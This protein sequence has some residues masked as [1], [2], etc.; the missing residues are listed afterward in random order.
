MITEGIHVFWK[1]KGISSNGFLKQIRKIT[2]IRKVGHAGTLDPLAEGILVVGVGKGTKLLTKI[3]GAEKE[4]LCVARLG[5]ISETDDEEGIKTEAEVGAIPVH[6]DVL[7]ALSSFQNETE[8]VPPG[9]S[10]IKIK[11]KEAYKLVRA[12]VN[13]TMKSRPAQIKEIELISY[14]WPLVSFRIV[15]GSGVYIRAVARDLGAKL[16]VGGYLSSLQ[17][18]RVG[19]FTERDILDLEKFYFPPR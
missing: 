17:R 18:I 4:Y 3:T 5:V 16:S 2:G 14:E 13:I 10:A 7:H 15:T 12:G 9:Y 11:G 1:P 8:Q 19:S 6:A